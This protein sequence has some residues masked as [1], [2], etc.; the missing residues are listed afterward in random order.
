[1]PLRFVGFHSILS[2]SKGRRGHSKPFQG[3][4]IIMLKAT[5][6]SCF[7]PLSRHQCNVGFP[8]FVAYLLI[9]SFIPN[10]YLS[11]P[12]AIFTKPFYLWKRHR[13]GRCAGPGCQQQNQSGKCLPPSL[14]LFT[15]GRVTQVQNEWIIP[16]TRPHSCIH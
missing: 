14:F 3:F 4:S 8:I 9:H 1:M 2:G 6:T 15:Q 13:F 7:E 5:L 11:S 10:Y 16:I 12:F